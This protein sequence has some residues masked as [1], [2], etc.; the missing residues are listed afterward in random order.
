MKAVRAIQ[1]YRGKTYD[2]C[3]GWAYGFLEGMRLCFEDWKP[4]LDAPEGKAW[5]RP[6]GLL[7][8]D[9]FSS[10]QDKLTKTPARRAKITEQIPEAVMAIHFYWLP[11]RLTVHER[12]GARGL[13]QKV[14]RKERCPCVSGEK[15]KRC[16]GAGGVTH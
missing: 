4:M 3:E 6:I 16:C 8:E 14:G 2:Q 15:F 12:M 13:Q 1:K 9:D 11:Y 10:D 7:G 5:F